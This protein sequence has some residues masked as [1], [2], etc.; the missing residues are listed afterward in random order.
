MKFKQLI[1]LF[2]P[3]TLVFLDHINTLPQIRIIKGAINM[4]WLL[5]FA[6]LWI[7]SGTIILLAS[8]Y[9]SEQISRRWPDW[10]RQYVV[11]DDPSYGRF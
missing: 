7:L 9:A 4:I 3:Q 10:W 6:T 1:Y 11:D 5:E 2:P 8:W